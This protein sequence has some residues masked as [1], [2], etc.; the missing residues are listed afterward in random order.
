MQDSKRLYMLLEYVPGGELFSFLRRSVRLPDAAARFY[1]AEVAL[2]FE[3]LH[4]LGVIYRDLK[5]ENLLLS[6]AG[7]VKIADFG[8]A[9]IVADRTYS[10][11][12]TPEYLA[13]EIIQSTGH[14]RGAD[15][16]AFGIL[17]FEMLAGYHPFQ[18]DSP[19][20]MYA[21]ILEGTIEFPRCARR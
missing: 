17:I 8:F 5:P 9:K 4:G 15:W 2:A 10:L 19:S 16:W 21:R 14:S 13:P 6:A 11:C 7:H 12:G 18:G 1:A 3:Y 20:V